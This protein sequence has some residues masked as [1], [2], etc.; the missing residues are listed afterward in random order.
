M[1]EQQN[2]RRLGLVFSPAGEWPWLHSHASTPV[3]L[4]LGGSRYRVYFAS[5]DD[6]N[7]SHATFVE[8][9][10]SDP[11]GTLSV[12]DTVSLAPGPLGH[13]DDH[14]I[15]PTSIVSHD[16]RKHMFYAGFSPGKAESLFYASIGVAVSEDG[17]RTFER[18][19]TA[20]ILQRSDADPCLVTAPVVLID[21]GTWRMW[22]VSGERWDIGPGGKLRSWYKLKYAE[23]N[24]G[25]E[26][27]RDDLVCIDHVHPN[28]RNIS[29]TCVVKDGDIYRAWYSFA[30]D[31]P[32]QL[33][34][35]ESADG[36]VWTR[37]DELVKLE[38]PAFDWDSRSR[39]Y[40]WVFT[41]AGTRYM[42][43]CGD[44]YGRDGF[45]LAVEEKREVR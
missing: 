30:G 6:K 20:P 28:E 21:N 27:H 10:L 26:W 38:P 36:F 41:H 18:V 25:L 19:T 29:R 24:D 31:F 16:G 34:Y 23:S 33:G 17:G 12:P 1:A 44:A 5:R 8:F 15:Y 4:S 7:R 42:L 3:P 35:A 22:Y 39:S 37:M 32:Y 14:G 45:G 43:Y 40:P 13:F 2:W 11:Q 9:D